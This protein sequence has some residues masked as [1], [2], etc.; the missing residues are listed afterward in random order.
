MRMSPKVPIINRCWGLKPAHSLLSLLS[1]PRDVLLSVATTTLQLTRGEHMTADVDKRVGFTDDTRLRLWATSAAR[2]SLCSAYLLDD[3]SFYRTVKTGQIAHIVGATSGAKSPRGDS[4]LTGPERAEANNL[5]LLCGSCH[6]RMDD[7]VLRELYTVEF[8]TSRKNEHERR[9]REV[10][11]FATL[12][13]TTVLRMSADVRGAPSMPT[14]RQISEALLAESLTG[15]GSD[16][17]TG[18]IEID[19]PDKH[20]AKWAWDAGVGRIEHAIQR[21][22][23]AFAADDSEVV[24]VFA[25]API[26]LLAYLGSQL[27]DKYEVRLFPRQRRDDALAWS[28]PSIPTATPQFTTTVHPSCDVA[29][30]VLDVVVNIN[31]SAPVKHSNKT[32][33]LQEL[34]S[35]TI[36]PDGTQMGVEVID[37]KE[38]LSNFTATWRGALTRVEEV[39]P[40]CERIHVLAAI[41]AT[42]AVQLGRSRMRTAQPQLVM[43][44]LTDNGYEKAV[45]IE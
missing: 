9:V 21:L 19:L 8:L 29:D 36:K 5:L 28:W 10:T 23:S 2:C 34:P 17:R 25:L 45:T 18:N 1:P 24:S 27:D 15:F 42:A 43:Y 38:A 33:F 11:A 14:A 16:T 20:T 40:R 22:S 13:K 32:A 12:R 35:M 39:W 6:L 3:Q 37:S 41:P 7:M 30:D 44:Q 26:P 4:D 31:V